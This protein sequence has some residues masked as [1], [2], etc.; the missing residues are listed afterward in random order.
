M[1]YY[2]VWRSTFDYR[3]LDWTQAATMT[4]TNDDK[5]DSHAAYN[6]KPVCKEYPL[7][8][9]HTHTQREMNVYKIWK[10]SRRK[11]WL[12]QWHCNQYQLLTLI[13]FVSIWVCGKRS[14]LWSISCMHMLQQC[15]FFVYPTVIFRAHTTT[16][17]YFMLF[18]A[19]LLINWAISP[20]DAVARHVRCGQN[21][22]LSTAR[23]GK[24]FLAQPLGTYY[25]IWGLSKIADVSL[26]R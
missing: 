15:S 22:R 1:L 12:Y 14:I 3:R 17:F 9:T 24:E 20:A 18:L 19:L 4:V 2:A 10:W 8:H 6:N 25:S 21:G 26:I 5:N 13:K 11:A 23:F 7:T 16:Q